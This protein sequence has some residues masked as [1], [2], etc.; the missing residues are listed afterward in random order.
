LVNYSPG[1]AGLN[2]H[3]LFPAGT[4]FSYYF[5]YSFNCSP[6]TWTATPE[7]ALVGDSKQQVLD[8]LI[9]NNLA[10][11]DYCYRK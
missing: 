1:S 4:L 3:V 8:R 5:Q 10:A 11:G 9:V 7:R 6:A 2:G